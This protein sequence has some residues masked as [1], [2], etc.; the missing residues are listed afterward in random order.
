[1]QNLQNRIY[2]LQ[3]ENIKLTKEVKRLNDLLNGKDII[4]NSLSGHNK[5]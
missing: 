5:S 1:M 2:F 3:R 4:K